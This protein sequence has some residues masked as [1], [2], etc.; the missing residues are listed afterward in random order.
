MALHPVRAPADTLFRPMP[1]LSAVAA[2]A[3]LAAGLLLPPT[4]AAA[5]LAGEARPDVVGG[6]WALKGLLVLHAVLALVLPRL[7]RAP[8]APALLERGVRRPPPP[9]PGELALLGAIT[10]LG[11]ALRLVDLGQGLWFDEVDTLVH[12]VRRP[13]G[14]VVTTFDSQNQHLLYS[15]LANRTTALLGDGAFA[16]RLPAVLLGTASLPAAWWLARRVTGEPEA[17]ATAGLLA[18][19]YHHVWFSQNARGYTGLLLFTLLAS[20]LFVDLCARAGRPRP[21]LALA[22]GICAALAAATHATAVLAVAAHGLVWLALLASPRARSAGVNR[23]MPGVGFLLAATLGLLLY[24][25]VLP[26]FWSTLTA[27]TMPGVETAWKSPVWMVAETL[28]GLARGL[29]GG[30]VA[31]ALGALVGLAGLASY[32]RQGLAVLGVLLGGALLTGAVVVAL[33]HNLWPRF[34]FFAAAS[35]VLVA[36][37]GVAVWVDVLL[38]TLFAPRRRTV[39]AAL[40]GALALASALTVPRAWAPKQDFD[41]AVAYVAAASGAR[42]AL[43]TADMSTL[44]TREA[45]R[46]EGGGSVEV[47]GAGELRALESSVARTWLLLTFPTRLQAELPDLWEHVQAQYREAARFRGTVAGG[48]VVVMLREGRP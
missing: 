3:L 31:L 27:P 24:A 37:R 21:G 43:V 38:R 6:M 33:G 15:V 48:D 12:Y 17:M 46:A 25:P 10:V 47:G 30:W 18:V 45:L 14:V 29:P 34:F 9:R 44:P 20:R 40:Y 35:F 2:L 1:S 5:A 28:R 13:L 8:L 4:S 36:L 41:G 16:L 7:A 42:D 26:Q 23:W 22:Y 11:L 32:A 39:L 19:S